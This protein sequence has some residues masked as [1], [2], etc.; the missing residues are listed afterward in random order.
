[1]QERRLN[2]FPVNLK[3]R[4]EMTFI[5]TVLLLLT[6]AIAAFAAPVPRELKRDDITDSVWE[7][8]TYDHNGEET[9]LAP[10]QYWYFVTVHRCFA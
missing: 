10:G 8:L 9:E 3:P 5:R 4:E 1:M 6:F 2:F 7:L